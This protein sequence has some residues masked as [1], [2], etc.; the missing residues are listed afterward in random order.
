LANPGA[1]VI[2]QAVTATESIA[3]ESPNALAAG[4]AVL[5]RER[6]TPPFMQLAF[7]VAG[8]LALS[9]VAS[10]NLLITPLALAAAVAVVLVGRRVA[11]GHYLEDQLLTDHRALVIPRVGAAYGFAL[12]DIQSVEM[13]GTKATFSAGGR[14]LRFGFVRRQR[15]F[16][17]ALEAGAPH[18]SFEQRWD[19]NCAG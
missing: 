10:R 2:L 13:R 7:A 17:R 11:A 8:L 4:E 19:P 14:Q 3:A 15:A 9:G 16:R 18:I 12:D 1:G 5:W 6:R